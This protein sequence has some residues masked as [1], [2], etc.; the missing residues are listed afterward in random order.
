MTRR[1]GLRVSQSVRVGPFRF[2][3]SV[4]ISGRGRTW[5]SAGTRDGFGWL[6]VSKPLG[7]R[8]GR[9]TR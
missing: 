4:P 1:T 8:R 2:R 3:I 5:V 6:S 9:R 7:R